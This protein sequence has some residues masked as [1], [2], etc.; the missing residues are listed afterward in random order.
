MLNFVTKRKKKPNRPAEMEKRR[1]KKKR[2]K[3]LKK[4]VAL[5]EF[6]C[7]VFT[8]MPGESYSRRLGSLLLCLCDVFR[9]VIN[10]L[11]GWFCK[12]NTGL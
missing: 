9:S 7:L 5:A 12:D 8:H 3:E 1:K 4:E 2:K 6:L 10:S 11:V